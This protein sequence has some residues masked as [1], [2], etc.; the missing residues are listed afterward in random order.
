MTEENKYITIKLI[1]GQEIVATLISE[2]EL[3]LNIKDPILIHRSHTPVGIQVTCT[4]WLMFSQTQ[5]IILDK[6]K[7]VAFNFGL[8]DTSKN[9]YE[10]F[11]KEVIYGDLKIA[12]TRRVSPPMDDPFEGIDPEDPILKEIEEKI[13]AYFEKT[14]NTTI[15]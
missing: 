14:S 2:E 10:S 4:P 8:D 5:E 9:Q 12:Q 6:Q 7:I 13:S 15:H 11:V 1:S 3:E